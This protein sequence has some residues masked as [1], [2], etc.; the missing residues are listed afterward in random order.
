MKIFADEIF[1]LLFKFESCSVADTQK[2]KI[3]VV[4]RLLDYLIGH[5]KYSFIL[6]NY[7]HLS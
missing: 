4:L 2:L 5:R 6:Q 3:H 1:G 7:P